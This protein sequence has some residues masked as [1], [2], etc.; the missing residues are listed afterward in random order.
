MI[1]QLSYTTDLIAI[2]VCAVLGICLK[3]LPIPNNPHL[4]SYKT[5]INYLSIAYITLSSLTFYYW[6]TNQSDAFIEFLS[7]PNFFVSSLQCILVFFSLIT[8]LDSNYVTRD[9][10]KKQLIP[11][12][13]LLFLYTILCLFFEDPSFPISQYLKNISK[14]TV[15]VR[16]LYFVYYCYL[17]FYLT[18][19]FLK[20]ERYYLKRLDNYFSDTIH[21]RLFRVKIV[22]IVALFIGFFS[23]FLHFAPS[24]IYN[25]IFTISYTIFYLLLA[26]VYISYHSIFSK[27]E[28]IVGFTPEIEQLVEIKKQSRRVIFVWE[29]LKNKIIEQ[30]VYLNQGVTIEE[31]ARTVGIG[32]TTLSTFINNE[33]SLNFNAWINSLRIEEAKKILKEQPDITII[34]IAE[35]TGFSEQSNFSKQFKLIT[36]YSP[37]SWR[38]KQNEKK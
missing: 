13:T 27:I 14:P 32:R 34:T 24:S 16:S 6:I 29:D 22:F 5:S 33:E 35:M 30:K 1:N 8:L 9:I 20:T 31:I 11:I 36:G 23:L 15:I 38:I 3:V 4:N 19:L 7:F 18:F 2:V 28:P 37:T 26:L 25:S 10:V 21:L 17:L 12:I